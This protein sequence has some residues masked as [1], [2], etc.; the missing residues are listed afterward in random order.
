M[1]RKKM[2]LDN[3]D[4]LFKSIDEKPNKVDQ[5]KKIIT[6]LILNLSV[7]SFAF[8]L[9]A[10]KNENAQDIEFEIHVFDKKIKE[11]IFTKIKEFILY[12]EIY[13]LMNEIIELENLVK[14]NVI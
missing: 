12:E 7:N 11:L 13:E 14:K 8:N 2:T 6:S 9:V 4:K 1:I 10:G 3:G 5:Y